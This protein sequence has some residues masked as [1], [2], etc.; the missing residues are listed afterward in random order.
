MRSIT[1]EESRDVFNAN[2]T[3]TTGVLDQIRSDSL[4]KQNEFRVTYLI[5]NMSV[6]SD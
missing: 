1:A 5:K 6:I 2:W 3:T 4:T